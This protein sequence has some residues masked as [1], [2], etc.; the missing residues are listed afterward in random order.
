MLSKNVEKIVEMILNGAS[1]EEL[2]NILGY[3]K[4]SGFDSYLYRNNIKLNELR[5]KNIIKKVFKNEIF[6]YSEL[7]YYFAG[8]VAADGTLDSNRHR[9]R[10]VLKSDDFELIENLNHRI[11]SESNIYMTN[12][13]VTETCSIHIENKIIYNKLISLGIVPQKTKILDINFDMIP[14]DMINHFLRGYFDGDG[15][16]FFLNRD[17]AY[18]ASYCGKTS[19]M[20]K[21]QN[22]FLKN[23][24]KSSI[25]PDKR[26]SFSFSNLKFYKKSTILLSKYLYANSTISMKRKRDLFIMAS[27]EEK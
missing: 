7:F 26:K 8:L 5:G 10:I 19:E 27:R 2:M 23:G 3:T 6:E 15:S 13:K 20:I 4:R 12:N 16:I 11:F 17:K 21:M 18:N 14:E 22:I 1:N 24:I 25:Y 9:I